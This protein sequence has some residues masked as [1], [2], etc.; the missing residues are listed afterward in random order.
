MTELPWEQL[1]KRLTDTLHGCE[2]TL[3]EPIDWPYIDGVM[4]WMKKGNKNYA[5]DV[6][7]DPTAGE[8][9]VPFYLDI[10]ECEW[11]GPEIPREWPDKA[12]RLFTL[13][14]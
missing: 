10:Y 3:I 13:H 8:D 2:I 12:K 14:G 11:A 6:G 5:L 7:A 4:I 9:E 1:T